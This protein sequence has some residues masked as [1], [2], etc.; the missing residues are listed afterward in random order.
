MILCPTCGAKQADTARSCSTCGQR[1]SP[2]GKAG[3][4]SQAPPKDDDR[5]MWLSAFL[6]CIKELGLEAQDVADLEDL[7]KLPL[8]DLAQARAT[9]LDSLQGWTTFRLE[10]E[11]DTGNGVAL[12]DYP[13]L[14]LVLRLRQLDVSWAKIA[15]VM[16]IQPP[17][18]YKRYKAA[19]DEM[20]GVSDDEE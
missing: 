9:A 4:T 19:I 5:T 11:R 6:I 7:D 1:L 8:S 2:G 13:E 17:G 18:L 12:I 20:L 16:N 15:Q 3:K 10:L 14:L